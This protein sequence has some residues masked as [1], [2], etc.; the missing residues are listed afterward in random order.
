M[1]KVDDDKSEF[2]VFKSKHNNNSN[3]SERYCRGLL[4]EKHC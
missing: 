4:F 2:N 3:S 1:L